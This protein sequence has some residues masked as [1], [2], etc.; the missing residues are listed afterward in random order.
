LECLQDCEEPN[1]SG[2][3][4]LIDRAQLKAGR[5]LFG[6]IVTVD[7]PRKVPETLP[8]YAFPYAHPAVGKGDVGAEFR[9]DDDGSICVSIE[10]TEGGQ[11]SLQ[12]GRSGLGE[13]C[14]T[15]NELARVLELAGILFAANGKQPQ[16]DA[17]PILKK[18]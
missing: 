3:V 18:L 7:E 14:F 11:F 9:G 4:I 15:R 2:V 17:G 13:N 6:E 5:N 8:A 12:L 10:R 16:R 1:K